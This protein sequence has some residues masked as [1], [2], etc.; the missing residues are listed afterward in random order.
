MYSSLGQDADGRKLQH[1]QAIQDPVNLLK[2]PP[3][4]TLQCVYF[5]DALG[6]L[7]GLHLS[8]CE[9]TE[10]GLALCSTLR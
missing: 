1:T 3:H 4:L 7:H 5:I 2:I 8:Q 10:V 9:K 6:G